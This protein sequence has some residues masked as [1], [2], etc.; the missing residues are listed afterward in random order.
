MWA[1]LQQINWLNVGVESI[2]G[3]L[4]EGLVVVLIGA[5]VLW[6]A[7]RDLRAGRFNDTVIISFNLIQ[8]Q[9]DGR[10]LLG[11][12]TP[13]SGTL[14]EIFVSAPLIKELRAAA[15]RSTHDQPII[16]LKDP[17]M[18]SAMQR[19]LINFCNQLNR[20]GQMAAL[21]GQP[22]TEREHHLA[23]VYEP[24]A[25]TKMFRVI[26][27]SDEL[28]KELKCEEGELTFTHEYH[29]DRVKVLKA[30]AAQREI[31]RLLPPSERTLTGF[32]IAAPG[33]PAQEA[34]A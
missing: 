21:T 26:P 9:A 1:Q 6:R 3:G 32:M 28:L 29:A 25:Q 4:F 8:K 15:A 11:F 10:P 18:H 24:G 2:I 30:I 5:W 27:V 23:L 7:R 20:A 17:R 16:K 19:Q 33:A 31:D 34:Q 14:D 12:R 22:Y 13:L